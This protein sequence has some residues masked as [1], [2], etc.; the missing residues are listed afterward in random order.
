[1]TSSTVE[2]WGWLAGVR[3]V[4]SPNC[5]ERPGDGRVDLVVIHAISLPPGEFG[6]P[7]VEQLFT[8][9]LDPE[10]HPYFATIAGLRVSA[11]LYIDRAGAVTQ[12][13]PPRSSL[14]AMRPA[15]TLP[16]T[17]GKVASCHSG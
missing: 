12:F 7:C 5:D 13:V 2:E 17:P 6:G 15:T 14:L 11:H 9:T 8:N 10:A 3:R 1:M 16:S 4:P